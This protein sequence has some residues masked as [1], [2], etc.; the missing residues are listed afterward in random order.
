MS[1][2]SLTNTGM[3]AVDTMLTLG[4]IVAV[5]LALDAAYPGGSDVG[6]ISDLRGSGSSQRRLAGTGRSRLEMYSVAV[7]LAAAVGAVV[8]RA[9]SSEPRNLATALAAVWLGAT[10]NLAL[11]HLQTWVRDRDRWTLP[12]MVGMSAIA[13]LVVGASWL[14][15][16]TLRSEV[17]GFS[18]QIVLL[19]GVHFHMAGF[20]TVV[21]AG[22][23]LASSTPAQSEY[24]WAQRGAVLAIAGPPAVAI[25]HLTT[26][27]VELVG[28]I[29]MASAVLCLSV[30]AYLHAG[31]L[32]GV[33][34]LV[35]KIAAL[36]PILTM[37]LAL[38]YALN[39]VVVVHPVSYNAIA[40]I[41]GLLNVV[42]FLGGNL[43]VGRLER[44]RVQS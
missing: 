41:H 40:R 31:R 3:G 24:R 42:V 5:P 18:E 32:R 37:G 9:S 29:V 35:L 2:W 15:L 11:G 7:G 28:A 26:G 10:V 25:G 30:A 38:H 8:V 27:G 14:L 13:Y 44:P 22:V 20:A 16:A 34:R 6:K 4:L 23:R 21:V 36:A 17:L 39:R 43:L 1:G 12:S 33:R 19:T